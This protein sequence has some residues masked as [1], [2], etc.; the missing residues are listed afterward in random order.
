MKKSPWIDILVAVITAIA[1]IGAA[2]VIT[3][4]PLPTLSAK[5]LEPVKVDH[6]DGGQFADYGFALQVEKA[7]PSGEQNMKTGNKDIAKLDLTDLYTGVTSPL[8]F[9]HVNQKADFDING[10]SFIVFLNA[11]G[12]KGGADNWITFTVVEKWSTTRPTTI[13]LWVVC[14]AA[15]LGLSWIWY[16]KKYPRRGAPNQ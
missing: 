8:I 14:A 13:V 4:K 11:V 6:A 7:E 3:R 5:P 9:Q 2:V 15:M 10:R 12:G 16:R 1:T